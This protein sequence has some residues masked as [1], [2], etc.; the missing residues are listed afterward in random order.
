MRHLQAITISLMSFLAACSVVNAG[1]TSALS[2]DNNYDAIGQHVAYL[3][4]DDQPL[5]ITQV[6]DAYTSGE[7]QNWDR[8]V[9]SFGIGTSPVWIRF[10]VVNDTPEEVL[11]RLIIE[12]SWLDLAELYI[13]N[14]GNLVEH[15]QSGDMYRFTERTPKHRF[16]TFDHR[17]K[18]GLS[19]IYIR[20]ATP[21]PMVLPIFFGDMEYSSARDV[22]NGYSYGIFYG[23][24][25][26]LLLYNLSLFLSIKQPRYFYY[27][28]YLSMF[29]FMNISY[30]GHGFSMIWPGSVWAQQWINPIS[31]SLAAITGVVFAFSFLDIPKLFPRLFIYTRAFIILFGVLQLSLIGLKLQ[32]ISVSVAIGLV[33]LFSVFTFYCAIISFHKGHRD[34]V[35][36][37]A[38]TVATIIGAATT[39]LTVWAVIPYTILSY[40]AAEI[41]IS[42]DALLLSMALA[43]QIRRAN[44]EKLQ[45]QQLARIDMLTKLNN[46]RAF[47]ELCT[48]IWHNA[49]RHKHKL[50]IILLDIDEFKSINDNHGHT[51]GDLVLKEVAKI[52]SH[53]IREGDVLARWG[54][55]EFAVLLPMTSLED[56]ALMANRIR[57]T[58]ANLRVKYGISKIRTTISAGVAQLDSDTQSIEDLFT[59]AD[60]G[61]YQAKQTGRNRVCAA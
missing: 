18:P 50:C 3:Q 26:A 47:N 1:Q 5:T 10:T 9:L 7:F 56:A 8:P 30:T 28:L 52:L 22:F 48:P 33:M 38:A 36:Y 12:N 44:K 4:E 11:R 32:T 13:F 57:E 41:A 16:L 14:E 55:E 19:E 23:I 15:R 29:M 60:A 45:A 2:V 31:I 58:V 61:L 21:D 51:A 53:T 59:I 20:A 43:E 34:A 49:I 54:G 35:Y 37:L 17:Y 42:I 27:V 40:R 39:A 24:L 25:I 46:R 6:K